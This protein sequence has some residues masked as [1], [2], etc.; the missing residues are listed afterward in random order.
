MRV[1][2]KFTGTNMSLGYIAGE[3]YDLIISHTEVSR[4]D[5][6]GVCKYSNIESFLKNWKIITQF[7]IS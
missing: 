1:R 4:L 6:S 3:S 5:G 2:A 7:K